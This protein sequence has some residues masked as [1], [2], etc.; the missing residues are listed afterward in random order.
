MREHR[1]DAVRRWR[2]DFAWVRQRVAV[3]IEGGAWTQGRH[4][5][6]V[7][8]GADCAKYNAATLAGW[9]VLR[10]TGDMLRDP[11]QCVAQVVTL[12][13]A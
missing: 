8:F 5:R 11:A 7:G 4:T 9:R 3:E 6:G 10:F 1:F 13:E 12:L 2:F